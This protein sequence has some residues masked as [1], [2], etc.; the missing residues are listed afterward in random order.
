MNILRFEKHH[1]PALHKLEKLCFSS[2]WSERSFEEELSN[3]LAV[4]LVAED[5]HGVLGYVGCHFVCGEGDI[6]NIAVH[7]DSRRKGVAKAL[8]KVLEAES[9]N[10]EAEVINLEVRKSNLPAIALYK[11]MGYEECGERP[12]FYIKPTENAILMAKKVK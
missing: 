12:N 3:P 7:P 4:F 2:P 11:Q 5:E 8:L 10:F 9:E 1:I 6:T